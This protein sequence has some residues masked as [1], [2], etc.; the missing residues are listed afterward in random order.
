MKTILFS[1]LTVFTS[2]AFASELG[3]TVVPEPSTVIYGKV[4]HRA[5]GHEHQLTEGT[6][7][8]TLRD[9]G[10]Q[11]FT[12]TTELEDIQG[13]YSYRLPIPHQAFTS[14]LTVDPE[15]VPLTPGETRYEFVSITI[16]GSPVEVI[17]G[18]ADFLN[19]LQSSRAAT[20]R[21][22]LRTGQALEDTDGDGMPDWWEKEHGLDWQVPDAH[23][24]GNGDGWT[25]LQ[26]YLNGADP[27]RDNRIPTLLTK[28]LAA[29]A[30]S[31]NGVWLRAIDSNTAP[32]G[33]LFTLTHLPAG[34]GLFFDNGTNTLTPLNAGSTFTQQNILDGKVLFVQ[35]DPAIA[36]TTLSVSLTDGTSAP[37]TFDVSLDVFSPGTE[38]PT[39]AQAPAWWRQE[40]T[41]FAAYWSMRENVL[42]GNFIESS[43]FYFLGSSYGWTIWDQRA[44]TL[45]VSISAI[46]GGKHFLIGGDVDDSLRGS[47]QDDILHGGRGVNRLRGGNGQDMFIVN[48]SGVEIIEDFSTV[49]DVI[50][51]SSLLHGKTGNLNSYLSVQAISGGT[52]I[53]MNFS[54]TG[55]TFADATVRLEGATLVQDDL[56]RLWS[57]GQLL[58]GAVT[59]FP[60]V[61]IEG[62]PTAALEEA[63]ST[64]PLTFRRRGPASQPLTVAL[65][66][67]GSAS[68]GVDYTL[69][70]A[71]ITFA[72]GS[73]TANLV[74]EPLIDGQTEGT[75]VMQL[76]VAAG[77]T[78]VTGTSPS[79]QI[80]IIDAQQRFNLAADDKVAIANGQPGYFVI[81]R[82]AANSSQIQ[83]R[84]DVSGAIAGTDYTAFST[85]VTFGPNETHRY[86]EIFALK[87]G[88]LA[89]AEKSKLLR[90]SLRPSTNS[91][92]LLGNSPSAGMTLLSE[93]Q[94]LASWSS[95]Q[96]A[97]VNPPVTGTA[98]S[99][100]TGLQVLL[101][102]AFSYGVNL[103]D[104]VSAQERELINPRLARDAGGWYFEF[105]KRLNDTRLEYVVERSSDLATWQSDPSHFTPMTLPVADQNRGRVRYRVLNV[106]NKEMPFMRV[107]VTERP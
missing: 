80:Q 95:Q 26:A 25:N 11:Q 53:R 34:G 24:D 59:G 96:L 71:S 46:G 68:N 18:D 50:D 57:T 89:G 32:S 8:W 81:T 70:P 15:V 37:Q 101:E 29:Y 107:R 19:L 48:K 78:Y 39:V 65:T 97:N 14:G 90:V 12:Y 106:E 76:S 7:T 93:E 54:G 105:T 38:E 66:V 2:I 82:T 27:N 73:S 44:E 43:L 40:N 72:A 91:L 58:L 63:F 103:S 35:E 52:E 10:G 1:C 62:W 99:P 30:S 31:E 45:P 61:S 64:A 21:I 20:Y 47:A 88:E 36:Q 49:Q 23:L 75:E 104:G 94:T 4:L 87:G 3:S 92:Y 5:N 77:Q 84:L 60:S 22:D 9:Q 67:S 41:I 98:V 102:Y 56:H 100:R 55:S 13:T 51:L 33:L 6:L 83:V 85:L 17:S 28:E 69:I 86:I 79:G 74:I 16:N 42:S